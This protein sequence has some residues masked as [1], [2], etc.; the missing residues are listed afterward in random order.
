MPTP[1]PL[2]SARTI[3]AGLLFVVGEGCAAQAPSLLVQSPFT[4][5]VA[6]PIPAGT[7]TRTLSVSGTEPV[8]RGTVE[9]IL[10]HPKPSELSLALTSPNGTRVA[11]E[12]RLNERGEYSRYA[13]PLVPLQGEARAGTW[14][15]EVRNQGLEP[16]VLVTWAV[17]FESGPR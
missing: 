3:L 4:E 14:T 12:A 5:A 1:S 17:A 10:Q 15:L 7:L 13:Q 2:T 9:V 8:L 16:G 6:T 11:V